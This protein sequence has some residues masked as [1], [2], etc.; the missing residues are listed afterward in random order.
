[1]LIYYYRNVQPYDL[2]DEGQP[3]LV[4]RYERRDHSIFRI[5]RIMIER[6]LSNGQSLSISLFFTPNPKLSGS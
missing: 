4:D 3:R 6:I 2:V 5:G 1:M